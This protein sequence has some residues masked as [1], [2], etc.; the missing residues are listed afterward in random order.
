MTEKEVRAHNVCLLA[1][2]RFFVRHLEQE[3]APLNS[4]AYQFD[5]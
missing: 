1:A 2:S 3:D 4:T 5:F